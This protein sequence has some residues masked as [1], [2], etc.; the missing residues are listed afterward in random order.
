[1]HFNALLRQ[2]AQTWLFGKVCETGQLA[3][4]NKKITAAYFPLDNSVQISRLQAAINST[5]ASVTNTVAPLL[6]CISNNL[7][8]QLATK[9]TY[10]MSI[11][12]ASSEYTNN[13]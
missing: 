5:V 1:M 9:Y 2:Q 11:A 4:I 3:H 13:K 10:A 8:P 6:C 7:F 12:P